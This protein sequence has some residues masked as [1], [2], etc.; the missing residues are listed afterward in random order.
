MRKTFISLLL[1]GF[2]LNNFAQEIPEAKTTNKLQEVVTL[3]PGKQAE[4][5]TSSPKP[6][7]KDEVLKRAMNFI[8]LENAKYAKTNSVNVG[9]KTECLVTFKYKPKELN[10]KSD[11]EGTYSMHLSVEAKDGKYRYTITKINHTAKN[12]EFTGG[13]VYSEVP[14][15]GSMKISTPMWKQMKSE[16]LKDATVLISDLKEGMK[17][18]SDVNPEK[19]E[20]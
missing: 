16:A 5:D 8:R 19:D 13:D 12:S 10:P 7:V 2:S 6:L 4:G 9:T 17:M 3:E 1:I 11:V 15:C 14:S 18:P 20:W